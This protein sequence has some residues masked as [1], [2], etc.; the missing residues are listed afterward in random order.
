MYKKGG[1]IIIDLQSATIVNDLAKALDSNKP[2]LVY[3]GDVANFYTLSY[4][5][6]SEVYTLTGAKDI[7]SVDGAG[8]ITTDSKIHLYA[9]SISGTFNS[10]VINFN[11]L[12]YS[13][14]NYESGSITITDT[15][16]IDFINKYE[17]ASGYDNT[18]QIP[19]IYFE[20]LYIEDEDLMCNLYDGAN[21]EISS[22]GAVTCYITKRF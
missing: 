6:V 1:Y 2:V 18:N 5:D 16:I 20:N 22:D 3:D 12:I 14:K 9:V 8:A 7:I 13:D 15:E 19:S 21:S 10:D 17:F 4:D 11:M